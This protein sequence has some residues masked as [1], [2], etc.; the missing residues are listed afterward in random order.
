METERLILRPFTVH[1]LPAI[2]ALFGNKQT[3]TFLPW[4]PVENLDQAREFFEERYACTNG[5]AWAICKKEDNIPVGSINVKGSPPY[6]FGYALLPACWHQGIATEAAAAVLAEARKRGLPYVT[7]THDRR[8]PRSGAVM[9]K[10]G[11][12]Y[13]YS[14]QEQWQPK[15]I[16]VI[17]RLY[18]MNWTTDPDCMYM[19]Y[20]DEA[21]IRFVEDE[22]QGV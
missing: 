5:M 15:N 13:C 14:Y 16:P 6:D 8:N 3:N 4:F 11:M 20:W 22:D 7:A 1:D 12:K 18:Q 10:L 19:K 17:F 2:L 21:E 9:K